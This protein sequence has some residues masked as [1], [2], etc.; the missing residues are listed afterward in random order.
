M[1]LVG[2]TSGELWVGLHAQEMIVYGH[3][4]KRAVVS[5][6]DCSAACR[7]LGYFVGMA[8]RD[9]WCLVKRVHPPFGG[10]YFGGE[11]ADAPMGTAAYL[12]TEGV[13]YGLMT[14]ANPDGWCLCCIEV[15]N[16]AKKAGHPGLWFGD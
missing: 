16:E 13:G 1:E 8:K 9:N 12:A 4:G 6:G 5:L 3:H 11:Q 15:F 2:E 7:K 10:F 14:E